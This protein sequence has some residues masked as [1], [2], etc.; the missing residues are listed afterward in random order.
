MVSDIVVMT[1]MPLL[2]LLLVKQPLV[3]LLLLV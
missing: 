2:R 3:L 1:Q